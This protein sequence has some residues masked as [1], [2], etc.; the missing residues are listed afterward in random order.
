MFM[1]MHSGG[2][3]NK[4]NVRSITFLFLL[5]LTPLSYSKDLLHNDL[6]LLIS[7]T[8]FAEYFNQISHSELSSS[9]TEIGIQQNT[10]I[11][12][13]HLNHYSFK[14]TIDIYQTGT[15]NIADINI[16]GKKNIIQTKQ[17]GEGN[18]INIHQQSNDSLTTV[19]QFGNYNQ[20]IINI[21]GNN[22]INRI[23][24]IGSHMTAIIRN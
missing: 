14:N 16:V 20:V 7:Q 8:S 1:Q 15:N 18:N 4:Q 13:T 6:D 11:N 21:Q 10:S 12:Q 17:I 5:F 24:Q 19:E 3:F 22:Q 23:T 2:M 9:N